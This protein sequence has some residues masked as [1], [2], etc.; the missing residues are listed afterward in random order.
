M[1]ESVRQ[2]GEE[3]RRDPAEQGCGDGADA[4][5]VGMTV[6]QVQDRRHRAA[7]IGTRAVTA[8]GFSR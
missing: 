4:G 2:A 6:G 1:D 7:S 8:S 5:C 3:G